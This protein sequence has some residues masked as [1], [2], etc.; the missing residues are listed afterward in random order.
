MTQHIHVADME[1]IALG[2]AVFGTGGGGDP[3]LGKLLA[4]N[5]I[6][7]SGAVKMIDVEHL[8]DDALIVPIGGV[9]APT[10]IIEKLPSAQTLVSALQ[11]MEQYLGR[12]ATAVVAL[13]IGGLNS[14]M[15]IGVASALGLPLLDGDFMGRA[16]PEIQ[17]TTCTLHG[18]PAAPVTLADDKGN[19][20]VIRSISN[21]YTERF[22]RPIVTEM[23][24][25]AMIGLYAMTGKQVRSALL[26]GTVSKAMAVGQA[27]F[28]ARAANS[29]PVE[30]AIQATGAM[31]LF[32]A[33]VVDV[34]R[35]TE[36]GFTKGVARLAGIGDFK[37]RN[38]ELRFQ[39]EF[40]LATAA[41][42]PIGSTPDLL[43]ALDVETAEPIT[44]EHIRYG[45]RAA[46]LGIPCAPI[47][48]SAAGLDV[49][50]PRY[51]GFDLDYF[52]IEAHR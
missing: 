26:R 42:Q 41:G 32:D 50:G 10:V 48:R 49:V 15:P 43:V 46:V 8:D 47:W 44:T 17:M 25:A 40:L 14:T 23:G 6:R 2:S 39:N 29:S 37:G 16:F 18:I 20:A 9:G 34:Q 33:K 12:R 35:K 13:E 36:G 28:A 1:P 22:V 19:C 51:F 21:A 24:G 31:R 7:S 27:I 3:Y 38:Y 30:A 4:Q 52:P 5:M 11:A 45:L